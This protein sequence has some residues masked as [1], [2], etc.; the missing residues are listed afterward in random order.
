MLIFVLLHCTF[1]K[2]IKLGHFLLY[3]GMFAPIIVACFSTEAKKLR[4]VPN[5]PSPTLTGVV[6]ACTYCF[7]IIESS[8]VIIGFLYIGL[9]AAAVLWSRLVAET[10]KR[11]LSNSLFLR[12]ATAKLL[13]L[14]ASFAIYYALMGSFVQPSEIGHISGVAKGFA[15]G[16]G[17]L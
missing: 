8:H 7:S 11:A 2:K 12:Y 15:K 17:M 14:C 16:L 5:A 10:G 4:A 13:A 6:F 3:L 9:L 1:K